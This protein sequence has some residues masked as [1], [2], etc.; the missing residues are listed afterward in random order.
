MHK[1][2]GVLLQYKANMTKIQ[3][4]P[5]PG[6]EWQYVFF[7]DF[8]LEDFIKLEQILNDI[9][10]IASNLKILGSYKKGI[11]YDR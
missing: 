10:A 8:I 5:E 9:R 7:I 2:L 4:V 3:S 11:R 1:A 6:S